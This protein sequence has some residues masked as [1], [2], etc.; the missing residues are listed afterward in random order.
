MIK[1]YLFQSVM[2]IVVDLKFDLALALL[3]FMTFEITPVFLKKVVA[4]VRVHV[5]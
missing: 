5:C 4:L 2:M 1:T 3:R